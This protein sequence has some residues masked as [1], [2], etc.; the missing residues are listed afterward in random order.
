MPIVL[1]SQRILWIAYCQRDKINKD[2]ANSKTDRK[3]DRK[4]FG[5]Y[6]S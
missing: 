4:G 2:D 1:L 5:K 6:M 3:K